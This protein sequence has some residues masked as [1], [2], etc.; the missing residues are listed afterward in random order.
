MTNNKYYNKREKK[1]FH[2]NSNVR[3]LFDSNGKIIE[4]YSPEDGK[5]IG[6][7]QTTT[8]ADDDKVMENATK[9]FLTLQAMQ[10]HQRGE[11]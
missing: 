9:A 8:R 6:K 7:V 3:F 11:I 4:S 2:I 10:E 5:L 1:E